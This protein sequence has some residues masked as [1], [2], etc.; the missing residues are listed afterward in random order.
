MRTVHSVKRFFAL[1]TSV[2]V[3]SA[4]ASDGAVTPSAALAPG[5]ALRPADLTV[6]P[7]NAPAS[8]FPGVTTTEPTG[9][10]RNLITA[11]VTVSGG[12]TLGG[13]YFRDTKQWISLA[14]PGASSTAMYGPAVTTGGYR[15]VG[16]YKVSGSAGDRGVIY[17]SVTKKYLTIDAPA[18][19]CAPKSCNYTIAHSSFGSS[20][21]LV[22]GN[23]DA[24]S[25]G[26]QAGDAY[27]VSGHAFLYDSATKK[28]ST[29]DVP[30]AI[31]TTA[32]GIWIDGKNVAVAGGFTDK[33]TV[34]A[35]VRSLTG[36]G[37]L[38]YDYPKAAL[39]HF[40]GI[41]GAGG[42]GNYNVIG[43]YTNVKGGNAP[44]YGFFLQIRNW[45]AGTPVVIGA[46]SA[47]SVFQRTA[48]GVYK[49]AG[50]VSGYTV[51]VPVQDPPGN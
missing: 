50:K 46:L 43:D 5:A 32:Y 3:L 20:A 18:N 28:F 17:N 16:S 19:L 41:T 21:Y 40:E 10:R 22:V 12:A 42:P 48:I 30:S 6:T 44:V 15:L 26:M 8:V 45:K 4:C 47:N 25:S 51:D 39:T 31:S 1:A 29:I 38:V 24:V 35:Y 23:Y 27:P 11:T 37:E 36:S 9:I 49:D 13:L 33:K 2:T 7:F 14:V 34:H